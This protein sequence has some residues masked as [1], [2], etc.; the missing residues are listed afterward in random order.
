MC[1]TWCSLPRQAT[2][3][4]FAEKETITRVQLRDD[5]C[6]YDRAMESLVHI[7]SSSILKRHGVTQRAVSCIKGSHTRCQVPKKLSRMAA[8]AAIVFKT[9]RLLRRVCFLNE[10]QPDTL[11]ANVGC[12]TESNDSRITHPAIGRA[13]LGLF[14]SPFIMHSYMCERV[15]FHILL[16]YNKITP[17]PNYF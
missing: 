12:Q 2:D 16:F 3:K 15:L 8:G 17:F 14:S 5:V 4:H 9:M 6:K 10:T 13:T 11:N 1:L 7:C